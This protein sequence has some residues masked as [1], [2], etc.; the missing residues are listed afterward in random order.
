MKRI[1]SE[2]D[3]VA[4]YVESFDEPWAYNVVW[5][6]DKI[7]QE[8]LEIDRPE[9][10]DPSL[11]KV[12]KNVLAQYMD[13]ILFLNKNHIDLTKLIEK[14]S[15]KKASSI[16]KELKNHFGKLSRKEAID[17]ITNVL[18]VLK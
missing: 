9:A 12:A 1:I 17:F 16:Y 2:I 5:K 18:K 7:A 10:I 14:Q 3:K 11:S 8:I 4:A 15:N 6:L 13:G